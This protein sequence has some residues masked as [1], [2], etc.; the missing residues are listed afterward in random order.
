ME[1]NTKYLVLLPSIGLR[2]VI[3]P[4]VALI[5][6]VLLLPG[7]VAAQTTHIVWISGEP[8]LA[9]HFSPRKL[10]IP[11]GDS[12]QWRSRSRGHNIT[13]PAGE[14]PPSP[15]SFIAHSQTF[16]SPGTFDYLCMLH[17]KAG[18]ITVEADP[19]P[20]QINAGLND[21]WGNPATPGQ[22]FFINVFPSLGKM[23]LAWITYDTTRPP[24]AV[25]ANLGDPG[26]RWLTAFG[27]YA[28]NQAVLDIVITQGGIFDAASPEPTH[29]RDGTVIVDMTDCKNG[30]VT[31]H[32]DSANLHGVI[33]IQRIALDN[34]PLC[35][36][37]MSQMQQSR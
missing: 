33:P 32:I 21:A 8:E 4:A 23:F 14:F 37:I 11:V 26:H 35:Q 36:S 28:D 16:D 18:T 19:V 22:G 31:Y 1:L 3:R 29:H 20:F 25:E 27:P 6:A 12:V 17:D 34:V 30:T 10:T 15:T 13:W 5:V 7:V 2:A 24:G 9:I